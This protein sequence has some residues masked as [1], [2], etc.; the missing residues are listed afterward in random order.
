MQN[1]GVNDTDCL[2]WCV[3]LFNNMLCT[4][5]Q[6]QN[7]KINETGF[8]WWM[9]KWQ[10][11]NYLSGGTSRINRVT[12]WDEA[13][14]T[15]DQTQCGWMLAHLFRAPQEESNIPYTV[16]VGVWERERWGRWRWDGDRRR[17]ALAA[18]KKDPSA[19]GP[20]LP[21]PTPS[22]PDLHL[23][24]TVCFR[25]GLRIHSGH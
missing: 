10:V 13:Q 6:G 15:I 5:S 3:L 2:S 9:M 12:R 20:S 4:L 17:I 14:P 22:F 23:G 7:H 18:P 8:K 24:L 11:A 19:G 21:C 16:S 25:P 1:W